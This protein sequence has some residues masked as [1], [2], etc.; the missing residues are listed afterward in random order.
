M[1]GQLSDG[2]PVQAAAPATVLGTGDHGGAP[3]AEVDGGVR[4]HHGSLRFFAHAPGAPKCAL[5]EESPA[6]HLLKLELAAAAREA[7]A[8]AELEVRGPDGAWRADVLASD[9]AGGWK[10][11]LEAQL[12]PITPQDIA[13]RTERMAG[14]GVSS[15][16]FSDRVRAPWFG[17]VPWARLQTVD[18]ALAVVEGLAKFSGQ[19]WEA[20][21]R[22]P[23]GEFLRWVFAGRVVPH[24][25]RAPV[26]SPMGAWSILWTAPQY[27]KAESTHLAAQERRKRE[28]EEQEQE[29][30]LRERRRQERA[31][32]M[33]EAQER[34][35]T[36]GGHKAAVE[37]LRAR[38]AALE[39]PVAQ[40]VHRETGHYPFVEDKGAPEYAMGLPVHVG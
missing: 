26:R 34:A 29:R 30:A 28:Q 15:V 25:R 37:A 7:G 32:E 36:E 2:R 39:I 23:V 33:R 19:R 31:R 3:E 17:A 40:F 9:P 1:A 8:H 18:G 5:A 11:A 27:A 12:S 13:A 14:D 16:W 6:H 35:R 20:G 24:R 22:V 10:T 4:G 38:Q 21:P